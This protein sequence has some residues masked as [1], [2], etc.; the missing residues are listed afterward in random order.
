VSPTPVRGTT[1]SVRHISDRENS[2]RGRGTRAHKG[3]GGG[4]RTRRDA[5]QVTVLRGQ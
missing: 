4:K 2:Q 3:D 1:W 5:F